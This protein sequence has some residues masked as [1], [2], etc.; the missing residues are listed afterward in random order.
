[1]SATD[2]EVSDES[3]YFHALEDLL[4]ELRGAPLQVP[5]ADYRVARRWFEAGIPL[6]VAERAIRGVFAKVR[7]REKK[8]AI[9]TLRYCTRAV[10]SAWQEVRELTAAGRREVPS[11][12]ELVP[13]DARLADL[14]ARLPAALPAREGWVARLSQLAGGAEEVEEALAQLDRELLAALTAGLDAE[15]RADLERSVELALAPV[16]SRLGASQ[17]GEARARLFAQQL[18][19][20]AGLPLLSLFADGGIG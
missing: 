18:R 16:A 19:R 13:V 7:E 8:P 17:L 3:R 4:I 10:E 15:A 9:F 6:A 12:V 20:R 1:M 11:T 14:A 2:L 5:P